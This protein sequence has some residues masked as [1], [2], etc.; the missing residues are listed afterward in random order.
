MVR[1]GLAELAQHVGQFAAVRN[2]QA[3]TTALRVDARHFLADVAQGPEL[4][5]TLQGGRPGRNVFSDK[6]LGHFVSHV[7]G[8]LGVGQALGLGQFEAVNHV[9]QR[10]IDP[11]HLLNDAPGLG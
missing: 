3:A 8:T 1:Y 5:P 2:V 10:V 9:T 6:G 11:V 4:Y 7:F